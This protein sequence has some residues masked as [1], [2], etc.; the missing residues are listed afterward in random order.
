MTVENKNVETYKFYIKILSPVHIGCGDA[1]EPTSFLLDE[2]KGYLTVFNPLDFISSLSETEKKAF[3][4]LC[5]KGTIRSLLEIYHFLRG[6]SFIG[7]KIG[8]CSGF[9]EHYK[10][11]LGLPLNNENKIKQE[12]NGFIIERTAFLAGDG[13]PYI[14]GSSVKGA[15]RTGYLNYLNKKNSLNP[16]RGRGANNKLEKGLLKGAFGTDP[17]RLVKVSDFSPVGEVE[18]KI[19]YAVNEKKKDSEY[20]ASGPYQ[21]L[22]AIQPGSIFSGTIKID[23]P[24]KKANIREKITFD[25]LKN[26]VNDFYKK[27]NLRENN[28]LNGINLENKMDMDDSCIVMRVGRHSGCESVTIDGHRN[29]RIKKKNNFV[30]SDKA[31][32][33]WFASETSKPDNPGIKPFGWAELGEINDGLANEYNNREN[34][35][36][37]DKADEKNKIKNQIKDKE[38]EQKREEEFRLQKEQK[39]KELK[40]MEEKRRAKI[41]AMSPYEKSLFELGEESITEKRVIEIYNGMDSFSD[42]EK[43]EIAKALKGY[44]TNK[45]KWDKKDCSKKQIEK[46]KKIKS[47]LS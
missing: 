19:I 31:T 35:Y 30:F 1:Y 43:V 41:E 13:R 23:P 45:N 44:W 8:V 37:A 27:E 32:T 3:L 22:E 11:T 25:T 7:R 4:E 2:N 16:Q 17:F 29:I 10:K 47:I 5:E 24:H 28:E 42:D 14:P 40:E 33:F 38:E 26:Y 34:N 9:T 18:A 20:R 12:L 36:L 46:V 39:E 15:L 6:K 21:I